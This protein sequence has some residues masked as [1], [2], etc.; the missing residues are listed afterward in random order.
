MLTWQFARFN[1]LNI[2]DWYAASAA[3]IA[4]FVLEQNCPF[5]DLDGADDKSWHLLGWDTSTGD[6]QLAAYCRLVDAD[7]KFAVPSIGRVITTTNYRRGGFGKQLMQEACL[8][9]DALTP[10]LPNRIGAQARLEKFYENFGF[11]TDSAPYM[12]DGIVHVEMQRPAR[13][14]TAK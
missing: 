11:A 3:R 13:V 5:Q 9:H 12:E 7:I 2:A 6:K 8:R 14:V 4:V 10:N 1:Q